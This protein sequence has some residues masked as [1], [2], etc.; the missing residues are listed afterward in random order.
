MTVFCRKLVSILYR[1]SKKADSTAIVVFTLMKTTI[2]IPSV[3]KLHLRAFAHFIY[4]II[5][6]F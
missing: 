6:I 2:A 4:E 5:S 3:F 1:R